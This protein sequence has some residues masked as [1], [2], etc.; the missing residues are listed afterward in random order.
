M[1]RMTH[2]RSFSEPGILRDDSKTNDAEVAAKH[3]EGREVGPLRQDQTIV[4]STPM[5]SEVVLPVV[6]VQLVTSLRIL[7]R[8][9]VLAEV[10]VDPENTASGPLLVQYSKLEGDSV[11]KM[12]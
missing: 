5:L 8:Q 7:P 3:N 6:R 2:R 11:G 10:K 9:S 1:T 12:P 4:I